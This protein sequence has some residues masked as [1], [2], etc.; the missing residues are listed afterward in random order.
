MGLLGNGLKGNILTGLAIG[1]GA[2]VLAPV[3]IPVLANVV[4][5]LAKAAL[6]GGIVLYERGLET[7][8]ETKEV[9]E[10]L[11]AEAK[12]ELA[13]AKIQA[14]DIAENLDDSAAHTEG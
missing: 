10:D 11:I 5:P 4:K 1:I 8:A 3:V 9:V 2:S 14:P 6:K 13:E 7:F 12:A